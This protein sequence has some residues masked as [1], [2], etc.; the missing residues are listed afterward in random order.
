[1]SRNYQ[2]IGACAGLAAIAIFAAAFLIGSNMV[3]TFNPIQDYISTL[4]T[5]EKG[6]GVS[7]SLTAFALVGILLA[8]FG[9]TYGLISQ[10]RWI[11]AFLVVAGA[12]FA[13]AAV[14]TDFANAE[15]TVSKIHFAAICIALGG[16]CFAMSRI[17][18]SK[19]ASGSER[20][21]A[22]YIVTACISVVILQAISVLPE[23]VS[24]RFLVLIIFGWVAATCSR[25][26]SRTSLETRSLKP[27]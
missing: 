2:R 24:H 27:E 20:R 26:L 7:W 4:G 13:C 10:D 25:M 9:W 1:M 3:P 21:L 15:S 6:L 14:P 17:S 23:P 8:V 11:A 5:A 16:W 22:K 18:G 19:H 12:G